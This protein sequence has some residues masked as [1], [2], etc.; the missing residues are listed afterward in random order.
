MT[1]PLIG[2]QDLPDIILLLNDGFL[3]ETVKPTLEQIL[4]NLLAQTT[5]PNFMTLPPIF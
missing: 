2:F 4:I 3:P 1:D 5:S